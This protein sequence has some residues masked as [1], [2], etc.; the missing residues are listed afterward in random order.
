MSLTQKQLEDTGRELKENLDKAG[1]TIEQTAAD[2]GT[3]TEYI[4]QLL[5]LEPKKLEDTWILK[6]YLVKKAE[7]A[8]QTPTKFTALGGNHHVIW[9]LNSRYIDGGKITP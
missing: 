2:L 9:F 4:E 6:E 3:T 8:G 5:R 1:I 7:E